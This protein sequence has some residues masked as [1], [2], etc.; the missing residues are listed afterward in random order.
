[1]PKWRHLLLL[2]TIAL[3][4]SACTINEAKPTATTLDAE[5]LTE[6]LIKDLAM[7]EM[8]LI[9]QSRVQRFYPES[10][11]EILESCMI[12]LCAE[13]VLADE[14]S[15]WEI[16]DSAKLEEVQKIF[17]E[18]YKSR[19]ELYASYAPKE[20]ERIKNRL[21]IAK[22]SWLIYVISDNNELAE[23]IITKAWK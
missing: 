2:I 10:I 16:K 19:Q 3:C 14:I 1:M 7:P 8:L 17:D 5:A 9:T 6:Q 21:V 15:I 20:A 12:Y 11:P 13:A 22:G 4:L 18:H 23:E